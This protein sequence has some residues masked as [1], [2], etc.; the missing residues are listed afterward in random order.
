MGKDYFA[1]KSLNNSSGILI[2]LSSNSEKS[3]LEIIV[4]HNKKKLGSTSIKSCEIKFNE[5][6]WITLKSNYLLDD[7]NE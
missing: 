6:F 4:Q 3:E 1:R 7:Q 2:P 5:Y